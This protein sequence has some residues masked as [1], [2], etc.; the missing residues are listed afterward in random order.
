MNY[1]NLASVN[2]SPCCVNTIERMRGISK[3]GKIALTVTGCGILVSL[4]LDSPKKYGSL[5]TLNAIGKTDWLA[6]VDV[7]SAVGI[8][9]KHHLMNEAVGEQ[10]NGHPGNLGKFWDSVVLT[11]G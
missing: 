3:R 6:L 9:T 8:V 1:P 10:T 7:Y 2:L 11:L 5:V 4:F